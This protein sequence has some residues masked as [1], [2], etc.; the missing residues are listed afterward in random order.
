[1]ITRFH[2]NQ[3]FLTCDENDG[4]NQNNNVEPLEH[5]TTEVNNYDDIDKKQSITE[6]NCENLNS[7]QDGSIPCK[8]NEN[9]QLKPIPTFSPRRYSSLP[10]S[11]H[12]IQKLNLQ[13]PKQQDPPARERPLDDNW[14]TRDALSFTRSLVFYGM[15]SITNEEHSKACKYIMEARGLRQKYHGSKGTKIFGS[16]LDDCSSEK[17]KNGLEQI[18]SDQ[19]REIGFHFNKDGLVE[20]GIIQTNGNGCDNSIK[21]SLITVPNIDEFIKDYKRLEVLCSDGAMRSFW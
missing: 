2:S 9:K 10:S 16:A 17:E 1:M 18:L 3:S 4:E 20:V 15:G 14:P 12:D 21:G 7:N 5:K 13:S 19:D 6:E 11:L 8:N